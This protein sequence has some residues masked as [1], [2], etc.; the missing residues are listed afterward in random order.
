M[1]TTKAK[2]KPSFIAAPSP[3]LANELLDQLVALEPLRQEVIDTKLGPSEVVV[4]RVI[5][6]NDDGSVVDHGENPIF[7]SYVRRQLVLGMVSAQWVVGRLSK[8]GQ[9]FRLE[10]PTEDEERLIS[11]ALERVDVS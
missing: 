5:E 3:T 2:P 11:Q 10:A 4:A 8:S 1:P 7:W 6:V 9:A